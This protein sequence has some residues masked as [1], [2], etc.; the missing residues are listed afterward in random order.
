MSDPV[1]NIL[2]QAQAEVQKQNEIADKV[3]LANAK[4]AEAR[5]LNAKA[6]KKALENVDGAV[7]RKKIEHRHELQILEATETIQKELESLLGRKVG[8]KEGLL[9]VTG[10]I[11]DKSEEVAGT[12]GEKVG[13]ALNGAVRTGHSL[14][15][16]FKDAATK[17]IRKG[18]RR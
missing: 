3:N 9:V 12:A 8:L 17:G 13:F 18:R 7:A 14:L 2:D 4:L 11:A 15:S 5:R 1:V 6:L 10:K 16:R